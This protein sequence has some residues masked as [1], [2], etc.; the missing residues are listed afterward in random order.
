MIFPNEIWLH[1][2]AETRLK[3]R[4]LANLCLTSSRILPIARLVLYRSVRLIT[5]AASTPQT[6]ALLARDADLARVV[7]DLTLGAT[8]VEEDVPLSPTHIDA[9]RNLTSL[10]CLTLWR[11]F[12]D[13]TDKVVDSFM[14]VI[15]GLGLEELN[16]QNP[17]KLLSSTL[18][19]LENVKNL[20]KVEWTTDGLNE[21]SKKYSCNIS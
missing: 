4:D 10:K 17:I 3:Q 5:N 15:G 6:L 13:E 20:K 12:S 1:I 7:I 2:S 21:G 9:F 14:E 18:N 16:I 11:V 8:P 19:P